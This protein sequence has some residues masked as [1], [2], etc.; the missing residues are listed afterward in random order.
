MVTH[1]LVSACAFAFCAVGAARGAFIGASH[2]L[3]EQDFQD[4]DIPDPNSY[5]LA[6]LGEESPF[7]RP[8]GFDTSELG[9]QFDVS[10]SFDLFGGQPRGG[11]E[12]ETWFLT[13]GLFDHDSQAAGDQI[14][15]LS[16]NGLDMTVEL[17]AL[18]ESYGGGDAQ[19]NVYTVELPFLPIEDGRSG[20]GYPYGM[21]DVR[22]RF[23][24]GGLFGGEPSPSNG[25]AIDFARLW[26]PSP[27][28]SALLAIVGVVVMARR[29]R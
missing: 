27:G 3:G 19:Y 26:V 11:V 22:L 13:L 15:E 6:N 2:L 9:N 12:E 10:F 4:G 14:A 28:G 18:S 20:R 21:I 17:N 16:L 23:A 25:G 29:R 7:D 5:L 8:W 24:A 1:L